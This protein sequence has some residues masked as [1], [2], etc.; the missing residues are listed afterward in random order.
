M[1][2]IYSHDEAVA[3]YTSYTSYIKLLH[4]AQPGP[5]WT[6]KYP[7]P[8][9]WPQITEEDFAC[10]G[11][12]D[13]ALEFMRH[14]PQWEDDG[15]EFIPN[16]GLVSYLNPALIKSQR[17]HSEEM[18]QSRSQPE[19]DVP[20]HLVCLGSNQGETEDYFNVYLDTKHGLVLVEQIDYKLMP[21]L[22]IPECERGDSD[23]FDGE[24]FWDQYEYPDPLAFKISEDAEVHYEFYDIKPFFEACERKLRSL[25]WC[26]SFRGR[27]GLVADEGPWLDRAAVEERRGIMR[28]TGWPAETWNKPVAQWIIRELDGER[29]WDAE[30][31]F[32]PAPD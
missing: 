31:I 26:P 10:D 12:T 9:D 24:E 19:P 20:G 22:G 3:A 2:T 7:P 21:D 32:G 1:P 29:D 13:V 30:D 5:R 6:L 16:L 4:L 15:P 18:R 17:E 27:G 28:D 14:I 23:D 11:T 8:G 25:E